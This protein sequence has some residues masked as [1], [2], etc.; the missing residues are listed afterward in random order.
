MSSRLA[1]FLLLHRQFRA[2]DDSLKHLLCVVH[3]ILPSLIRPALITRTSFMF[4]HHPLN[5]LVKI[6]SRQTTTILVVALSAS[7]PKR[8]NSASWSS[9]DVCS[10]A[11]FITYTERLRVECSLDEFPARK[12]GTFVEVSV[13]NPLPLHSSYRACTSGTPCHMPNALP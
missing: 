4:L 5:E 2:N 10:V 11:I 3:F 7:A 13:L 12:S 8:R 9:I 6:H 1:S